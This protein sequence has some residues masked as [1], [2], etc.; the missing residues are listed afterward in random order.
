MNWL[1]LTYGSNQQC[2]RTI[3]RYLRRR[4]LCRFRRSMSVPA[5]VGGVERQSAE[6]RWWRFICNSFTSIRSVRA[7][8]HWIESSLFRWNQRSLSALMCGCVWW[9][10]Y[11]IRLSDWPLRCRTAEWTYHPSHPRRP[12]PL[13]CFVNST[14]SV[15]SALHTNTH[16]R[17]GRAKPQYVNPK[18]CQSDWRALR[19]EAASSMRMCIISV[20]FDLITDGDFTRWQKGIHRSRSASQVA[21]C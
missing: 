9:R 3:R 18:K 10:T 5:R 8:S 17:W 14:F 19:T 20:P 21:W 16:T 4:A 15:R 2:D 11:I 1:R 12:V 7:R 6:L 13:P